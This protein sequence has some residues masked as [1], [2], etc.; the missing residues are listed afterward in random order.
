MN[1]KIRKLASELKRR[2]L[3]RLKEWK[4]F[5]KQKE[6]IEHPAKLKAIQANRR[7]G[8]S[9][10]AGLYLL[11]EAFDYPKVSVLYVS[12]T[13]DSCMRIMMKDVLDKINTDMGLRAKF[14]KHEMSVTLPNG[15][16]IYL[17][18]IDSTPESAN[19]ILG[20]KYRLIIIDEAAFFRNNLKKLI[21]EV[22]MPCIADYDGTIMMISTTSHMLNSFYYKV[23][24]GLEKGWQLFKFGYKDNPHMRNELQKQIDML[25]DNNPNVIHTPEFRRMYLNEWVVSDSLH[26]YRPQETTFIDTL[27]PLTNWRY[28]LGIDLGYEDSTAFVVACYHPNNDKMYII[29]EYEQKEMIVYDV[30]KVIERLSKKYNFDTMVID[31]ASK[32]VVEELKK[33]YGLPLIISEKQD[34]RGHI[35]LLN[36]DFVMDKVKILNECVSIKKQMSELLWDETILNSRGKWVEV[37]SQPNHLL[38]ATLYIHRYIYNYTWKEAEKDLTLEDK[39]LKYAEQVYDESE[40]E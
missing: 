21:F 28:V 26:V 29:E 38:D 2:A 14:N 24:N 11:K 4:W 10:T 36:S 20:Q 17:L 30:A 16:I 34:K 13:R 18:C 22:L 40:E 19:K 15:S 6:I 32:Q 1:I 37:K 9:Y 35:E 5:P 8:K 12:L 27:P 39:L 25:I 33:R 3:S 7:S 31:G 23:M